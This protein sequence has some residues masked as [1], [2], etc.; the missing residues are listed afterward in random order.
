MGAT[1]QV[2]DQS[3]GPTCFALATLCCGIPEHELAPNSERLD[4]RSSNIDAARC[5]KPIRDLV[6]LLDGLAT[7]KA[8]R[9]C[10][11]FRDGHLNMTSALERLP[12]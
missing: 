4:Q 3:S 2:L 8:D 9:P 1:D 7:A 10:R 11:E 6:H 5:L 12:T